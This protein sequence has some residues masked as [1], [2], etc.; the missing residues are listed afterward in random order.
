MKQY[1][2]LFAAVA[3]VVTGMAQGNSQGK[4][5]GKMKA[6]ASKET[7]FKVKNGDDINNGV[8]A[9]TRYSAEA[10]PS[11]NQPAKVR[12]AFQRDYPNAGNVLWSKYRGD[13]TATFNSGWG[14]STA[15]YHANGQRKDTRTPINR[16][17]LP[18]GTVWDRVFK[19]DR[20][21]PVGVIVQ[22]KSPSLGYEIFRIASQIAG[23]QLQYL[24]YNGN[25]QQVQYDY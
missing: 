3:I 25:G 12:A 14:R 13:W 24:F 22:I 21:N 19:R 6:K 4:G 11:K 8:W 2:L 7:K 9:G 5:K 18:T 16:V 17:Q 20:V 15:V 1:L 10:K 23:S